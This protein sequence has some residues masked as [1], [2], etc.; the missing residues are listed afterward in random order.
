M[1][2]CENELDAGCSNGGVVR[3]I[4]FHGLGPCLWYSFEQTGIR[5]GRHQVADF[6]SD[7]LAEDGRNVVESVVIDVFP[8]DR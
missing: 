5:R 4:H 6:D 3:P 2:A 7:A 1:Q 8:K